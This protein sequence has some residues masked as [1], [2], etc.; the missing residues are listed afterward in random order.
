MPITSIE[1]S[2]Y[3]SISHLKLNARQITAL[4]GQNGSGKSN[5]LSAIQYF[6]RN[7]TEV[8]EEEGIFD[9]SNPYR[10]E[11]RIRVTYDLKNVM[12]IVNHNQNKGSENY[13]KYYR[14]IQAI[15]QNDIIT[16]E[17][18]KYKGKKPY[19]NA[20]YNTRQII[21][22][23]FPIYFIDA[24]NIE[25]T[26]WAELWELV[27]DLL[28]LRYEDMDKVQDKIAELVRKQDTNISIKLN[29]LDEVLKKNSIDVKRMTAREMGKILSEIIFHGQVFQYDNRKLSEFSNGTNAFNFTIFLMDILGLIKTYKLKEPVI[30]LDEPEI[31]LHIEMID[32]LTEAI[33][34]ASG[35][36]QFLMSTHSA[37]CV[38]NL[39]ECVGTTYDIYHVAL[40][41]QHTILKK[42]RNLEENEYRERII[43][44]EA[45]MNSC[46]AKMTLHVEGASELEVFKN[47]YLRSL[48]P[49]LKSIEV[50][51]GMSDRVIYNLTAPNKRNYQTPSIA[52]VDMDQ[53]LK[54]TKDE[55]GLCRFSFI[56]L[57]DYPTE[58]E[59]YYYGKKRK[60]SLHQR[61]RIK[62]MGKNCNFFYHLPFFSCEDPNFKDMLQLIH[63][64]CMFYRIFTWNTTIEGVLITEHN[65][66]LFE[67]FMKQE[68]EPP[69]YKK[70][71]NIIENHHFT[72]TSRLNYIRLIFSGKSDFL[73]T[74]KEISRKNSQ[75]H[76]DI[77]KTFWLVKKTSGWISRW[78]EFYF[79]EKAEIPYQSENKFQYF[80]NAD[81]EKLREFVKQDFE[82][83]YLLICEIEKNMTEPQQY[84]I[85]KQSKQ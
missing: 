73:L 22:A 55:K 2:G 16:A 39:M 14:K 59:K 20:E 17:L 64:Y 68:L 32:Q 48:F 52:V 67:K 41:K 46:F 9:T 43:A 85:I 51:T 54:L 28:K 3:R 13:Q 62:S 69:D 24:R 23:L 10:N 7:L 78:L 63:N 40:K 66:S 49:V 8:W 75:L 83:L 57:K 58:K 19:W 12:K 61:N 47:R 1:I 27:G 29:R 4:I 74:G 44:T 11:I 15:F 18:I 80:Q 25:L 42:V 26:D 65:L 70:I 34:E 56:E 6:Y 5:L 30:I 82:E 36:I 77:K 60:I 53:R 38:K 21:A 37:R 72:G 45:Y 79:L 50:M 76:T 81:I 71:T 33:F 31:S 35:Q 84:A